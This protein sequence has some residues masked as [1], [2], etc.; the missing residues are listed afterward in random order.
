MKVVVE[1]S[2][3]RISKHTTVLILRL[4]GLR[5]G[6]AGIYPQPALGRGAWPGGGATPRTA[7]LDEQ[8]LDALNRRVIGQVATARPRHPLGARRIGM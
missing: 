7:V 6:E 3:V 1:G 5:G 2:D 4:L 8:I